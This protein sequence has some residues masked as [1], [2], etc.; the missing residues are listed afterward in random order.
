MPSEYSSQLTLLQDG[1]ELVS[2]RITVND[3]LRYKG[4]SFYQT[5]FG[6]A[7]SPV[8]FTIHDLTREGFP[9]Q[10]LKAEVH[11]QLQDGSGVKL[12]IG[13]LRQ[14]NVM[15]M[16]DEE[17]KV[18]LQDAGP[19]LDIHLSS[20]ASGNISYRSYLAYPHLLAFA[21]AGDTQMTMEDLGFSPSDATRMS[22]L[23]AYLAELKKIE[24]ERDA[25]KNRAAFAAAMRRL[26]LPLELAAELGPA[27]ATAERV[28]SRHKLPMLF[29]FTAFTPRMYTG[30]QV[31][32]DPGAPLVW[33]ASA[34]LVVGLYM[35]IYLRERRVWIRCDA[36]RRQLEVC[37]LISG[38]DKH[39][40]H[41][42]LATLQQALQGSARE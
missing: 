3:P 5:S 34:I 30:L 36:A 38:K 4:V 11:Q 27:I 20:P 39:P 9:A 18:E 19:A 13:D 8:E 31:A 25:D 23:S 28:L 16:A 37:A 33:I 40:L 32:R 15:N 42:T 22:L 17:G 41:A 21:R 12:T 14:H 1:R 10:P 26:E 29:S 6:D 2:K 35:M 24:G 7:G